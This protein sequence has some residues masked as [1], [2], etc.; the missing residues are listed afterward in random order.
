MVYTENY[1][2]TAVE[3]A[4]LRSG[5][6]YGRVLVRTLFLTGRQLLCSCVLTWWRE[7][8]FSFPLLIRPLI[9]SWGPHPHYLIH[10]LTLIN[11]KRPI[12]K[13]HHHIGGQGSNTWDFTGKQTPSFRKTMKKLTVVVQCR[14]ILNSLVTYYSAQIQAS[15]TLTKFGDKLC[16]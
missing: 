16:L 12:S 6:Q 1:L 15:D 10:Y 7:C 2:F 3:A 9:P 13:Y 11:S 8:N 5:C 14:H 4:S